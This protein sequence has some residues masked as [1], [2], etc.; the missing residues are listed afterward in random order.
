MKSIGIIGLGRFGQLM[1]H[2]LK[3]HFDVYVSNRSDKRDIADYLGVRYVTIEECAMKDIVVPCVP[4]SHLKDVLLYIA[5]LIKEGSF[6]FDVCSVKLLPSKWMEEI[7]PNN[8]SIL[9]THPLF[10][11][12]TTKKGLDGKMIALCPV[13]GVDMEKVKAFVSGLGLVPISATPQEHDEQMARSLALIHFLGNALD[14]IDIDE[15]RLATKTHEKLRELVKITKN[16]SRELFIDMHKYNPFV[17]SVRK[18]L[19]SSLMELDNF[20]DKQK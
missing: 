5:P 7:L 2:F 9:C 8:C 20:L 6:V 15:V 10:G 1:A 19:I 14:K 17:S 11:P 12:D 16:D 3:G 18:E 4:I 13:R